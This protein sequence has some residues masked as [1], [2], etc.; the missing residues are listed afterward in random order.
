MVNQTDTVPA[1]LELTFYWG[2]QTVTKWMN[3]TVSD[4]DRY[5]EGR[6]G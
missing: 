3:E 5:T 1:L 6:M 4:W 2:R